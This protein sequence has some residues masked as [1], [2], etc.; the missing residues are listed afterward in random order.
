MPAVTITAASVLPTDSTEYLIGTAGESL[1]AGQALF[2][3]KADGETLKRADS[4]YTQDKFRCVGVAMC[5]AADGQPVVYAVAGHL[6]VGAVLTAGESYSLFGSQGGIGLTSD[7]TGDET[8]TRIGV[9]TDVSTLKISLFIGYTEI[10][11]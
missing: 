6:T 11:G 5:N 8:I 4:E 10:T 7:P 9:A 2:K 3:D 1:S